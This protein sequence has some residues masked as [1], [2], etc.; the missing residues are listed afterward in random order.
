MFDK[1]ENLFQLLTAIG[2]LAAAATALL[3]AAVGPFVAARLAD[4]QGRR[5]TVAAYRREWIETLRTRVAELTACAE[6]AAF[7]LRNYAA[8]DPEGWRAYA[9]A[10]RTVRRLSGEIA[11]TLNQSDPGHVELE[12][13]VDGYAETLRRTWNDFDGSVGELLKT[14]AAVRELTRRIS[15]PEWERIKVGC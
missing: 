4:R 13:L 8:D 2:S 12:A 3:G 5:E 10:V 6:S 7:G 11:L 1:P 9:D 15:K 14:G